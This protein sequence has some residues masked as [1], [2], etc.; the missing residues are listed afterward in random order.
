MLK[1]IKFASIPVTD[2]DRALKFYTES[3][4]LKILT[5]RPFDDKQRWIELEIPGAETNVV[6]FTAEG[7]EAMIGS[8]SNIVFCCDKIDKTHEELSARGVEFLHPPKKEDW[9]SFTIFKDPDG[10]Q[11]CLSAKK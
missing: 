1:A 11:F 7:Q 2:Q 10:N 9:G 6:L 5:D 4:G 3:L 8:F